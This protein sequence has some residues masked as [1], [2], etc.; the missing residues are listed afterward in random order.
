MK[1]S[2]Q[3]YLTKHLKETHTD[4]ASTCNICQKSFSGR[5]YL[6]M[7]IKASHESGSTGTAVESARCRECDRGFTSA[8]DKAYHASKVHGA[9]RPEG[10][11][12]D[13]SLCD[14]WFKTKGELSQH[15]ARIHQV[16]AQCRFIHIDQ[17]NLI[18]SCFSQKSQHGIKGVKV[19]FRNL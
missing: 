15:I 10:V 16:E 18:I 2:A 7:H 8:K 11:F 12:E 4:T 19:R 13:C 14:K 6:T 9:P 17:N 3:Y 5:R 1:F